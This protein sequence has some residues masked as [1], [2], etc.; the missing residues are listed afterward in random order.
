MEDNNQP[1]VPPTAFPSGSPDDDEGLTDF[2]N[3]ARRET[4]FSVPRFQL[5]NVSSISSAL[6]PNH[7]YFHP[8][9]RGTA[10]DLVLAHSLRDRGG[11]RNV[12]D[13]AGR[14]TLRETSY[15]HGEFMNEV[16]PITQ[17][18]F[19][20]GDA[21]VVL[22][23]NHCFFPPGINKWLE[24][25]KAECPVCRRAL[26][27]REVKN[28]ADEGNRHMP[29]FVGSEDEGDGDDA[30]RDYV[31]PA[32]RD[33]RVDGYGIASL[34]P[35]LHRMLENIVQRSA[36][37]AAARTLLP[38]V[39]MPSAEGPSAEGPSAELPSVWALGG[40]ASSDEDT[41]D[42]QL[43]LYASMDRT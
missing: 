19:E 6:P 20:D 39:E 32:A 43:A 29:G 11:V 40:W 22:P 38:S 27:S 33:L 12:L 5:R 18:A 42:L 15:G 8:P 24:D 10:T 1:T 16:C 23:C 35:A 4:V 31:P 37:S 30:E 3:F 34:N 9:R 7:M 25:S 28:T 41:V 21:I 26:S 36:Y 13:A 17:E 2:L 14:E